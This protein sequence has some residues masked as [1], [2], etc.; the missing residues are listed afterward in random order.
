MKLHRKKQPVTPG[1]ETVPV[2]SRWSGASAAAR[3]KRRYE[4]VTPMALPAAP[5]AQ[6][7]SRLPHWRLDRRFLPWI[8]ALLLAL[9]AWLVFTTPVLRLQRVEVQGAA[10]LT[11]EEIQTAAG[12]FGQPVWL[13]RPRQI[14]A[15]LLAAFPRLQTATVTRSWWPVSLQVQVQERMPVMRIRQNGQEYLVD[16]E[17]VLFL[18]RQDGDA[19]P[20]VTAFAPLVD[21][22][23]EALSAQLVAAALQLAPAAPAGAHLLYDAR[24]G[25]GWQAPDGARVFFGPAPQQVELQLRLYRALLAELQRREMHPALIDLGDLHAPYFK[26]GY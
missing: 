5:G 10:T 12:V 24:Y 26:M 15:D 9:A 8:A 3:G 16:A 2:L 25:L 18:P 14:E 22:E 21:E 1:K 7:R 19:L 13:L 17:G 23:T 6:L 11:A 4:A 20:V